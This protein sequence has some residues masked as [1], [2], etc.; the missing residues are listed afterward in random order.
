MK[1]ELT[2][3]LSNN[4]GLVT[5]V[6]NQGQCGSCVA[7][8]TTAVLE[9]NLLKAGAKMDGLDISDQHLVDCAHTSNHNTY[10]GNGCNGAPGHGYAKFY[11]ENG[12]KMVHESKYPYVMR[13]NN[14]Q[15]LQTSYWNPGYKIEKGM[16]DYECS[17][18][19]MKKLIYKYGAISTGLG[20][21]KGFPFHKIGVYDICTST[22][23]NHAVVTVGW[24]TENG[25]DYWLIKNS[26]GKGWGDKG[27]I[28]VKRSKT[29]YI[30]IFFLAYL[31]IMIFLKIPQVHVLFEDVFSLMSSQ[32]VHH[33][34]HL[35]HH[36]L[37]SKLLVTCWRFLE[38]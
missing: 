8:A 27:Y 13:E 15:C 36:Q 12:K 9:T 1:L 18:E 29:L 25:V 31:S 24:G 7:F 2:K 19:K 21:D 37:M 16:W 10:Y 11:N 6:K 20:V 28:K 5:S 30:Q 38:N 17:D 4:V 26:W 3:N 32:L 14:Y 35:H 34:R 22:K 33:H 23:T